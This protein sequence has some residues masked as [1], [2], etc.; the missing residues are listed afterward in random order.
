MREAGNLIAVWNAE[1][2]ELLLGRG[3]GTEHRE[4]RGKNLRE[5]NSMPVWQQLSLHHCLIELRYG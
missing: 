5:I 4:M 1:T 2:V 3:R